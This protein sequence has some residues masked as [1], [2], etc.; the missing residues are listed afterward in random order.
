VRVS[1]IVIPALAL[2]AAALPALAAEPW[3]D[4]D[5][6]EVSSPA[7]PYVSY[8]LRQDAGGLSVAIDVAPLGGRAASKVEIGIQAAGKVI[9]NQGDARITPQG[10]RTR[11]AFH[12]PSGSLIGQPSDW[13]KLR[14]AFSVA[15]P[16]GPFG[17][18]RQRERFLHCDHRAAFDPLSR[19][20]PD[21]QPLDLKEHAAEVANRKKRIFVDFDQPL[22]GK[23]SVVIEDGQ[24]HRVRNLISGQ[25]LT[26]GPHRIKWDGFDEQGN[27]V[28]SGTYRWRA[29]SHPGI[30][31]H[32]LF[33]FYNYGR[34]PWRNGTETSNWL[35]D[36][37]NPVAA[38]SYGDR[39]YLGSP[40]AESG[41]NVIQLT[42]AGEKTAHVNFPTMIGIGKMFLAADLDCFY[43]IMEGSTLYEPPVVLGDGRW[44]R[45]RPLNVLRW[46]TDGIPKPY[47]GAHGEKVIVQNLFTGTGPLPVKNSQA[48]PPDNLGGAAL[49]DGKLYISLRKE[50]RI[51]IMNVADGKMAGEIKLENPGLIAADGK[52]FLA[53]FSGT[54]LVRI[55]PDTLRVIPLFTPK[56]SAFP[57]MGSPEQL[58]YGFAGA[59]PTGMAIDG[60]DEIFLSDNGVDQDIKVFDSGGRLLREIGKKGGRALNGPWDPAGVYQP[61]GIAVDRE[62][63]LWVTETDTFP[64]RNSVWDAGRGT[65]I[66]EFFG[67]SFYGADLCSFDTA[68]HTRWLGGGLQW[69]LDFDKQTAAPV[70]TLYHQTKPGQMQNHM[71]GK[72]WNFYHLDGRTFLIGY[73]Q[74]QSIYELRADGS[75][76]LWAFCGS[77]SSIAQDPRWTLPKAITD[78]PAIRELFAKNAAKSRVPLDMTLA[79]FGSWWDKVKLSEP[80]LRNIGV[81]WVDRNGDDLGEPG[82]FEVLPEGDSFQTGGWGAGNPTLELKIP[83]MMDGK[84]MLLTFKP[85]GFLPSGAPNYSLSKALASAVPLDPGIF[86][87]GEASMDQDRF[88]RELFN[89]SPMK[90]VG[91]DGHTLWSFPNRWINVGGSHES[92]LPERGVM[93]G[94]LYFLGTAPLDSNAEAL[95]MNGN[96]GRFFVMTTDGFYLDEMFKDVRVTQNTDAYLIGGEPFGGFF[97]RGED[98]HYY[99]QSGHTDYRIF[100]IDGLDRIKRSEGTLEVSPGQV[101][102][103]QGNAETQAA[104]ALEPKVASVE[105]AQPKA[106]L[107]NDPNSWPGDWSNIT[108]GN[109]HEPFPFVQVKA[110]RAGENLYLAYRV[111]D[112]SPWVNH[113][114][115]WTALFKTG[116]SVDFQFSTDPAAKPD[117]GGPVPGDRR[118]L[119]A[120]YQGRSIA[121]LY[122]YREPGAKSPMD[123]SSPWRSERV[124]RVSE[125][126]SAHISVQLG[127]GTYTLIASAPL[128]ELGLP[129][130]GQPA[131]LR[132][133]FGV[134]Y[135]DSAGSMDVLRSYWSNQATGLVN[136]VPGEVMITPRLWA[137]LKFN[138]AP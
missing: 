95:V 26:E 24:G 4:D 138:K 126:K 48:P 38:A 42:L 32:Y 19:D 30:T 36:H 66:K 31:P 7:S 8:A 99:L 114:T 45:R 78:L 17:R 107:G 135:G 12:V 72:Y 59:N 117:R 103:A 108:W 80:L 27:V 86:S 125:I 5:F 71:V 65:L 50:N 37:G 55:E 41:H 20:P 11:Y 47:D 74:G 100:R 28:A 1:P 70:S 102:A 118:L 91:A 119:I 124:D 92:P 110:V 49:L 116:D 53:A 2:L 81:L 97:G 89:G 16:G 46:T 67:P 23:A 136:D 3:T 104:R 9:L 15:W 130:A 63:K 64:R 105:E 44:Q 39:V 113:G 87:G 112:P 29:I 13:D 35:S 121:V 34:P 40:I 75:V 79:P 133:D 62:N 101:L 58:F 61:H 56:L 21:W 77:L 82:E 123:F 115:D 134:I 120:P 94:T 51:V 127:D 129:P 84:E 85:D 43:A 106:R 10:E 33:S 52:G 14:M 90:A 69:K 109:P 73:G 132:G 131:E 111:K 137:T 68:D 93:Q 76:K 128:A 98:G 88:G 57:A 83:A 22:D 25:P 54:S 18:D 6:T 122:S 60:A 96:H